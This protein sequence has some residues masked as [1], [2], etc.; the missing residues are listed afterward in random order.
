M[1]LRESI[2]AVVSREL[3]AVVRELEA[4]PDEAAVWRVPPGITNSAGTLALHLEGNLRH[5]IGAELGGSRYRRDRDREFE[6]RRVPRAELIAGLERAVTEVDAG[7]AALA[8][9]RLRDA[10]PTSFGEATIETADFLVHLVSH[11]AFH[12]GQIDYH[13]RLVTGDNRSIGP[14]PMSELASYGGEP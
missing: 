4:Y 6:R 13:R 8:D 3:Q 12:L 7:L 10:F 9:D 5:F 1:N 11:L 2:R 14:L